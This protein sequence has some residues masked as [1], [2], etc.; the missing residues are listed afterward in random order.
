[1]SVRNACMQRIVRAK[2]L[3]RSLAGNVICKSNAA[4]SRENIL[5]R[6]YLETPAS[7][8]RPVVY[9]LSSQ[10]CV[11]TNY[12]TA[13]S[14]TVP[15]H[16]WARTTA[17]HRET[18]QFIS[19]KRPH[20]IS[21]GRTSDA[22][23]AHHVVCYSQRSLPWRGCTDTLTPRDLL[24]FNH[25]HPVKCQCQYLPLWDRGSRFAQPEPVLATT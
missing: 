25:S 9:R 10:C 4:Y 12:E 13:L 7:E 2:S 14:Q 20:D 6:I 22:G 21:H 3:P 8:S 16:P 23:D 19:Q 15:N 1:M 5:H 24:L 17:R 18:S 11:F